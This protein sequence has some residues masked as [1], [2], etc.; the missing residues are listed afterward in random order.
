MALLLDTTK[1]SI[2]A[3]S[4]GF[5]RR[6]IKRQNQ[7]KSKLEKPKGRKERGFYWLVLQPLQKACCFI[8]EN[9]MAFLRR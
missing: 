1:K 6:S 9:G 2:P 7:R 8:V 5:E 3:K 4:T